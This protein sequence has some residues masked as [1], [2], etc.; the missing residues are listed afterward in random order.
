MIKKE[1]YPKTERVK[2]TGG[3]IYITEKLDGSNM[4]IFKKVEK[5][6]SLNVRTYS[7]WTK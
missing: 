5:Y 2:E 7:N 1:I 6:M 3:T 4:C